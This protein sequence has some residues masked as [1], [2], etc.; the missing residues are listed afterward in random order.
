VSFFL[1]TPNTKPKTKDHKLK[2]INQSMPS[3]VISEIVYVPEQQKL[4]VRFVSGLIYAYLDVPE[5]IY[6]AMKRA[7]VKGRFLNTRIKGHF[8]FEKIAPGPEGSS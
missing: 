7:T 3:T 4:L 1:K 6:Q 5:Q 8:K 2:T